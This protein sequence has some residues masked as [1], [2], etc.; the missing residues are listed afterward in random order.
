MRRSA[1]ERGGLPPGNARRTGRCPAGAGL[2][3][4]HRIRTD[5]GRLREGWYR[6]LI[7]A[8]VTEAHYGNLD[9]IVAITAAIDRLHAPPWWRHWA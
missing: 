5:S 2:G 8:E 7:A 4:I 6:R 1:H 9:T 3:A